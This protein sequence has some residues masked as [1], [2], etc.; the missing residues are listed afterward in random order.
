LSGVVPQSLE[1]LNLFVVLLNIF[2][3]CHIHNQA[4]I[5]SSKFLY[6]FTVIVAHVVTLLA[7]ADNITVLATTAHHA[8]VIL[9][10]D[11][12]EPARFTAVLN[13]DCVDL[14]YHWS[15]RIS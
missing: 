3:V 12:S 7:V 4:T 5:L 10:I 9:S 8:S 14:P 6:W 13:Q 11:K 1:K 2:L 15:A